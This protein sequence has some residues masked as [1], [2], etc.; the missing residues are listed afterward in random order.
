MRTN[1]IKVDKLANGELGFIE[2]E[3]LQVDDSLVLIIETGNGN[4]AHFIYR[5]SQDVAFRC[6]LL[7]E[8]G[9]RFQR[10]YLDLLNEH[11]LKL[12]TVETVD[13]Y[14]QIAV[15]IV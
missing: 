8:A 5:V 4:K 7:C 12:Q 15:P 3:Y 14:F 2:N 1:L 13:D 6:T 9:R 11:K 10:A